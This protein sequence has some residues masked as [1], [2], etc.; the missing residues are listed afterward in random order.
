MC[1]NLPDWVVYLLVVYPVLVHLRTLA[2]PQAQGALAV[3]FALLDGIVGNYRN[4]KNVPIDRQSVV[5]KRPE[6]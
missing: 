5:T 3:V 6:A 4:C 2:P 1:Q